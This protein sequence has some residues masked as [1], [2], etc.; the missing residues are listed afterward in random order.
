MK[1]IYIVLSFPLFLIILGACSNEIVTPGILTYTV[2]YISDDQT[3]ETEE[4]S[5]GTFN[6]AEIQTKAGHSLISWNTAADGSGGGYG[7]GVDFLMPSNDLLL[8]AQWIADDYIGM[9]NFPGGTYSDADSDIGFDHTL[10]TFDIGEYEITYELWYH[11]YQFALTQGY[12]F[13]N[14]GIEG[15]SGTYGAGDYPVTSSEPVTSI[16]WRDAMVW[17]NA[18][19]ELK[20]TTPVYTYDET[21]VRDSGD[22]IKCDNSVYTHSAGSYSLQTEGQWQYAAAYIDG[23]NWTAYDSPASSAFIQNMD[24][25]VL[26]WCSDL[27]GSYTGLPSVLTDY[28]G[29]LSGSTKRIKRGG[30]IHPVSRPNFNPYDTGDIVN[31]V[32]FRITTRQ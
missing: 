8:Y 17:V 13:Q 3:V 18:Y 7:P 11:V 28:Y 31:P 26:E 30:V 1:K 32:S 2:R 27:Y 12:Q 4:Y 16:S 23:T 24:D 15:T 19:N 29:A 5:E 22:E 21:V 9:V 20:G 14:P 10:S 6:P 25:N